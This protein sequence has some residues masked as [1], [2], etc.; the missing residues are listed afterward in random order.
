MKAILYLEKVKLCVSDTNS[1]LQQK[2]P[3]SR[4]P[5]KN[6]NAMKQ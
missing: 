2:V 5:S 6:T 4:V 3:I 1:P